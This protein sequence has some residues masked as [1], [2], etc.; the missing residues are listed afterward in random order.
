MTSHDLTRRNSPEPLSPAPTDIVSRYQQLLS[1]G[2]ISTL[3]HR[4][5][6]AG[7]PIDGADVVISF[8]H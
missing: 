3:P 5:L 1:T 7:E 8:V 4:T 2:C 6:R